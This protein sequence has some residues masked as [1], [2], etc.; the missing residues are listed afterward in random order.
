[1]PVGAGLQISFKSLLL[2][3]DMDFGFVSHTL[4][5]YCCGHPELVIKSAH[6]LAAES[7]SFFFLFFIESLDAC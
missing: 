2:S 5:N 7:G 6:V 1:M 4:S 3:V